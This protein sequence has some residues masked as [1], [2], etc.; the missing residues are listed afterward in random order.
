MYDMCGDNRSVVNTLTILVL[1]VYLTMI[2]GHKIVTVT[3]AIRDSY[4]PIQVHH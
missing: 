2:R 3:L 1:L 4:W